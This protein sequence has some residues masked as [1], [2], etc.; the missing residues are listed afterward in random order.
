MKNE[1]KQ[2]KRRARRMVC[3]AEGS[4]NA[5]TLKQERAFYVHGKERVPVWL[6]CGTCNESEN[7]GRGRSSLC[8][9]KDL[10]M[11]TISRSSL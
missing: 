2:G 9:M 7:G 11:T 6:E 8:D 3:G 4:A 5:K 1:K 10:E